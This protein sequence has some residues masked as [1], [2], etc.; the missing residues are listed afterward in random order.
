MPYFP[1]LYPA[2]ITSG[3]YQGLALCTA[4]AVQGMEWSAWRAAGA[5]DGAEDGRRRAKEREWQAR[6][7]RI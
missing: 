7:R 1:A 6:K 3:G 5:D 4:G 2:S